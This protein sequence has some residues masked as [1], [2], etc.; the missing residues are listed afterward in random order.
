[1]NSK[2]E[3]YSTLLR[4]IIEVDQ[5]KII[6]RLRS[7]HAKRTRKTSNKR[8]PLVQLREALE[9]S[10][11]RTTEALTNAGLDE[12]RAGTRGLES[13]FTQFEFRANGGGRG[14][15]SLGILLQIVQTAED[16]LSNWLDML[17]I[18]LRTSRTVNPNMKEYL[19]TAIEK[20]AR[21]SLAS[22][23]LV[24]TARDRRYSVF[25]NIT[26]EIVQIPRP[27]Q[28][29]FHW[30][31]SNLEQAC[32]NVMNYKA[33]VQG[34]ELNSPLGSF[35][36]KSYCSTAHK[37]QAH[38]S[39]DN[40][41]WKIHAEIQLL[42]YHELNPDRPKPR[43]IAS[44]KSAC[45]LCNLFFVL[46]GQFHVPRTHGRIYNRWLLPDWLDL[47]EKQ[48]NRMAM[49]VEQLNSRIE[50]AIIHTVRAGRMSHNHP[51]ESVLFSVR[52]LSS[53][54]LTAVQLATPLPTPTASRTALHTHLMQTKSTQTSL[55]QISTPPMDTIAG[56]LVLRTLTPAVEEDIFGQVDA[57]PT[58]S[59]EDKENA[60]PST[61]ISIPED[62]NTE[63]ES[64]RIVQKVASR[65]KEHT[66]APSLRTGAS[67]LSRDLRHHEGSESLSSRS[68]QRAHIETDSGPNSTVLKYANLPSYTLAD[69]GQAISDCLTSS[70]PEVYIKA[71]DLHLTLNRESSP[72]SPLICS[73]K[74]RWLNEQEQNHTTTPDQSRKIIN[75][76][77]IAEGEAITV[78]RG[79]WLSENDLL[80]SC[81]PSTLVSIR[82]DAGGLQG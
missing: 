35:L 71:G 43:I 18:A 80:V 19:P 62:Q 20:L 6:C 65:M 46:H 42:V 72:L 75:G 10:S 8:P 82:F 49:V 70:T 69:R 61:R 34:P 68:G 58:S 39:A 52:Q 38:V 40:K 78:D 27:S 37:F 59:N 32:Q 51:N 67:L 33:S 81:G 73:I 3:D 76:R 9:D 22:R 36:G 13:L 14:S 56:A 79:G 63:D 60:S 5:L 29:L 4:C 41:L 50:K 48:R 31:F 55:S 57:L 17:N 53:S 74:V 44:S 28:P 64:D 26:V 30:P 54:T 47:T 12:L 25:D 11:I 2:E 45:Y 24:G 77:G 16:F 1:V 23:Y 66:A 7:R 15:K 21:Y